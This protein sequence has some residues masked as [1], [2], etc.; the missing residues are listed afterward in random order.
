MKWVNSFQSS[1]VFHINNSYLN[2]GTIRGR[3]SKVEE[4]MSRKSND[5]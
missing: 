4:I 3:S 1:D 5:V 2:M